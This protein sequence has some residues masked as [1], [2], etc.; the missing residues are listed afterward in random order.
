[1]SLSRANDTEMKESATTGAPSSSSSSWNRLPPMP[2]NRFGKCH[3]QFFFI[4]LFYAKVFF[5]SYFILKLR[6]FILFYF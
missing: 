3:F 5:D 6:S 4:I 1:M 2:P